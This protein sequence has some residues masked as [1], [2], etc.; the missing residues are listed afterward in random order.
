MTRPAGLLLVVAVA[1]VVSSRWDDARGWRV[2]L[3]PEALAQIK[4]SKARIGCL[5][6]QTDGNMTAIVGR[7]CNGQWR[8][9]YKAPSEDQYK[10]MGVKA[11]TRSFCTQGMEITYQCG[12]NDFHTASIAGDAWK[13]PPAQLVCA[14]PGPSSPS[15]PKPGTIA[16]TGARI[17]CLDI[18]ADM[19]LTPLV[20]A[21]CNGRSGRASSP[22]ASGSSS[23]LTSPLR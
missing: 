21:A 2:A 11:K 14:P 17:G 15:R 3:G 12:S 7:A 4:V 1:S 20:A 5:D 10:K 19:N 9:S 22:S 18:Q 8:C 13:N 23:W 16:V 6:V